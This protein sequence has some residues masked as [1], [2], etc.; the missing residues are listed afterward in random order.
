MTTYTVGLV[1]NPNCGKTTIFNALTGSRYKV[2]NY[3]GVTVEKRCGCLKADGD[4]EIVDLPGIYSLS[5]AS[6]DEKIATQFLAGDLKDSPRANALV[7]VVDAS[8]LERNLFLVSQLIDRELPMLIALNMTDVAEKR[9]CHIFTERL[10]RELDCPVIPLVAKSGT[11]ICDLATG[12][13]NILANSKRSAKAYA[14]KSNSESNRTEKS[15]RTEELTSEEAA[16]RYKW[17]AQVIS[18]ATKNTDTKKSSLGSKLDWI[19]SHR[20]FGTGIFALLMLV[21]F[22]AIFSWSQYPMDWIDSGLAATSGFF[23]SLLPDGQIK[24]LV[25]DGVLAGVGSVVIFIPQIAILFFLLGLLEDS[26][27]LVRAAF[28]MD[29]FMRRIG[30]QGRSFIP[31]LSSFACAIPGILSTRTIPSWADRLT[32]I[33]VAPLMSCSARLPVYIVLIGAFIPN[34]AVLG[35]FSLPAIVLFSLYILG[36]IGAALVALILK[37]TVLKREVAF[38]VMELPPLRAPSLKLVLREVWDRV[39]LFLKSAGTIILACSI[40]LWFLASYPR[41]TDSSPPLLKDS[42]AGAIGSTIEPVIKP[43]GFNWEIGIGLL[44]S[45]AAREVF[46]SSLA[47]IYSVADDG[48][49]SFSLTKKLKDKYATGEFTLPTA[50]SLLVFYVFACQCISTLAVARRETG[51]FGWV[52][53]MLAYMTSL[54]FVASFVT[55]RLARYWIG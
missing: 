10:S 1:G 47:T 54:A 5:S 9:G 39:K 24:S 13:S 35:L 51:S 45:F 29:G 46:V 14:W 4:I 3:P 50:L 31:L 11:G 6:L 34:V 2:A 19:V 48:D 12:I 52:A 30:L 20:V 7:V 53:F 33:L 25:I 40:F 17:I 37:R 43:L 26:G 22:Q 44:A 18:S 8:N 55:Y 41:N 49:Q 16:L 23:A 42:Y 15:E 32:T 36:I 27:Y 21:L 28:L 38:L